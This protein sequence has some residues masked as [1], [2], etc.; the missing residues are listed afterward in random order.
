M[1]C[2]YFEIDDT[3]PIDLI[4]QFTG[5]ADLITFADLDLTF[6]QP[7][8]DVRPGSVHYPVSASSSNTCITEAQRT[9]LLYLE[10][11]GVVIFTTGRTF[12]HIDCLDIP[13]GPYRIITHGTIVVNSNGNVDRDWCREK[14]GVY[15]DLP[16]YLEKLQSQIGEIVDKYHVVGVS[17]RIVHDLGFTPLIKV[18]CE[19]VDECTRLVS[20]VVREKI[21]SDDFILHHNRNKMAFIPAALTKKE[22][23]KWIKKRYPSH[24]S[25]GFGDSCSD[26]DFMGLCDFGFYPK[27]SQIAHFVEHM[28][29]EPSEDGGY[30][31]LNLMNGVSALEILVSKN[32]IETKKSSYDADKKLVSGSYSPEDTI[33]LLNLIEHQ[34]T[35]INEVEVILETRKGHYSE[36]ISHENP[37]TEKY[38]SLFN[39]LVEK[40]GDR[41][42]A[43]IIGLANH[44][45]RSARG[46]PITIV[47]FL[48][49]GTPIG[50]LI[51]RFLR[52]HLYL[53]S[54]HYSISIILD[55]GIDENALRYILDVT[56]RPSRSIYFI[57]GWTAKGTITREFK[58]AISRWNREH[59]KSQQ[60]SSALHVVSDIGGTASIAS[61]RDDY[62]IPSGIMNAPVSGLLS[63][64]LLN[65]SIGPDDFH[66]S[67]YYEHLESHDR[68]NWFLEEIYDRIPHVEA[69][70][71]KS[72]EASRCAAYRCMQQ[73]LK[74]VMDTY[75]YNSVNKIKPGVAEASRVMTRRVPE[76]LILRDLEDSDVEHL[77]SLA[78]EKNV[79][80]TIDRHSPFKATALI[81]KNSK[82]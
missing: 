75:E 22:A 69:I 43:E 52:N 42:A 7:M 55:R 27:G 39:H 82:V 57:D 65:D 1:T 78:G 49:A 35:P 15:N 46:A 56:K 67:V 31:C 68:T 76:L 48:R 20:C 63:R 19:D 47:S 58:K 33:F 17:S 79:P 80:I 64:S 54:V 70:S 23:V 34:H 14:E 32:D 11:R 36:V 12:Q 77:V 25:L 8:K 37:P 6:I 5:D 74:S 62:A 73:F 30:E 66:G 60:L 21:V 26:L 72:D 51:N 28:G 10:K 13:Y 44:I 53:D 24:V 71:V 61:T 16:R 4:E 38:V 3:F 41:L 59:D 50:A 2:R 18:K 9:M 29:Y 40:H 81:K 45:A